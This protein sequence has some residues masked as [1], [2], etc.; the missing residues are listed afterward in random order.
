MRRLIPAL[1]V[2]AFVL[3]SA[4]TASATAIHLY[5]IQYD[6][7]GTDTGSNAS[8]NAEYVRIKNAAT[9][10]VPLTHWTLHDAQNHV[11]TFPTYKLCGGC[12]VTIHTGT[13]TNTYASRYWGQSWYVWNNTGDTAT[14]RN[15]VGTT[16]DTCRWG[17]IGAGHITC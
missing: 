12:I 10:G 5:Y 3:A 15:A 7:P 16:I 14:L 2:L 13:G 8:L 1:A 17:S 4:A 11:Y 9:V 6:S